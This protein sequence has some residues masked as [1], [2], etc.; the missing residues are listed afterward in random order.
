MGIALHATLTHCS[1]LIILA[2]SVIG[3]LSILAW[4]PIVV[5]I[6]SWLLW[7]IRSQSSQFDLTELLRYHLLFVVCISNIT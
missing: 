6:H 5:L 1:V 2:Q 4:F 3:T 7:L